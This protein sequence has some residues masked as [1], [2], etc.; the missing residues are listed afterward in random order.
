[1]AVP[2]IVRECPHCGG[3]K[4]GFTLR[5]E[6]HAQHPRDVYLVMGICGNCAKG[7]I[8][9]YENRGNARHA[10][11]VGCPTDPE[12]SGWTVVGEYPES[13]PSTAPEFAQPP[14]DRL[15]VQAANAAKRGDWDASGAMSR[16]VVDVSTQL[17]LGAD[18]SKFG[19]IKLRIDELAKRGGL[20]TDL[21]DWAHVIRL[22]GNDAAHDQDPYTES[23][24]NELLAFA[25]LYLTYVYTLPGRLKAKRTAPIPPNPSA[26]AGAST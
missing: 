24:A 13:T 15:F 4:M 7:I 10:H 6:Y 22:E 3:E 26:A 16:K 19:T 8:I 25:D 2:S 12:N 5:V 18:A 21:K 1:M 9:E 17:L 11:P 14:L 23:E 20:T